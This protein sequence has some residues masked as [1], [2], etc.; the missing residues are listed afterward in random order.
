MFKEPQV[1]GR[2]AETAPVPVYSQTVGARI[3]TLRRQWR[4]HAAHLPPG[5][6]WHLLNGFLDEN[7][8]DL[9]PQDREAAFHE[10]D[11]DYFLHCRQEGGK[12]SLSA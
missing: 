12:D 5:R 4:E 6:Q 1:V 10:M 3:D 8:R 11:Y 2:C 9:S 7:A